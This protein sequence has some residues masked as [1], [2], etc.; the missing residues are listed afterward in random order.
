MPTR[1]PLIVISALCLVVAACEQRPDPGNL[2]PTVEGTTVGGDPTRDPGQNDPGDPEQGPDVPP[3]GGD[4]NQQMC[5]DGPNKSL[6][7]TPGGVYYGTRQP[8]HVPLDASQVMAVVGIGMGSPYGASCSGTL[9]TDTIVLTAKHCTQGVGGDDLYALFGTDDENAVL[10]VRSTQKRQHPSYDIA[11]FELEFAPSTQIDVTPIPVDLDDLTSS[12]IGEIFEQAGYGQTENGYSDGR[13][14][15]AEPFDG[16][17]DGGYLVVNGQGQHGVCFGDSGGP[18]MRIASGGDVRVAGTLGWGDPSCVGRDRYTRVGLVRDW[19]EEW[20]GP[21]PGAG[22]VP[23]GSVTAMGRCDA[24]GTRATYCAGEELVT[25]TCAGGDVCGWNEGAAGW[26]CLPEVDD[27]C[28]G[29]GVFGSCGGGSLTWCEQGEVKTRDCGACGESCVLVDNSFGYG[30]LEVPDTGCGDITYTGTCDG[31]VATWCSESG[32]LRSEDCGSQGQTCGWVN[33]QIGNYCG[34]QPAGGSGGQS[35][36]GCG[37]VTY[38]GS[39]DGDTA[40]WCSNDGELRSL[41]CGD[42]GEVC[43]WVNNDIGYYCADD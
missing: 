28:G 34:G 36:G 31:G 9:V 1:I 12:Q 10:A 30:C 41:D 19:I 14:F 32:E 33:D 7:Q 4:P 17:E 26:R 15:V 43:T 16:F 25:T 18:S 37:D 29:V 39:C 27:P 5:L 24:T 3:P 35:D 2:G 42:R 8:T 22:P 20:T 38:E 13:F 23:C 6:P 11:M 40:V 21:T